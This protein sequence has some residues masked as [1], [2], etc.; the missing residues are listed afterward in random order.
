MMSLLLIWQW[1]YIGGLLS[2][3]DVAKVMKFLSSL[4]SSLVRNAMRKSMGVSEHYAEVASRIMQR[5][6]TL[7]WA[8]CLHPVGSRPG[9]LH[10]SSSGHPCRSPVVPGIGEELPTAG[11]TGAGEE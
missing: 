4:F 2:G 7:T 5:G 1:L 3:S 9:Q 10:C 6:L 8:S 11:R